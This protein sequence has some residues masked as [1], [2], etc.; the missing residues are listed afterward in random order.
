MTPYKPHLRGW[1]LE[2]RHVTDSDWKRCDV[3]E[4][5]NKSAMDLKAMNLARHSPSMRFRVV[6]A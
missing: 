1:A 3:P 4:T 2:S 5:V 6:P